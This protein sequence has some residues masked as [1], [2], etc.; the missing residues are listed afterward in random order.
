MNHGISDEDWEGYVEECS[1]PEG[2]VQIETH[3]IGCLACWEHYGQM[4]HVTNQLREA[5]AA[6]RRV[7]PLS[8]RQLHIGLQIVLARSQAQ[9]QGPGI[10]S[11]AEIQARK[12]F[13]ESLISPMCGTQTAINALHAAAV[14]SP[15]RTLNDVTFENW[16]P[17]LEQL[18][19]IAT[20]M[21]GETGA[22]L[23]RKGGS[24]SLA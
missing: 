21:C 22:D 17:F 11:P 6:L 1:S 9:K 24:I 5:T 7:L 15:A 14:S 8:D 10:L 2:V 12:N 13:L 19:S 3:L 18:T 23:I 20:V 4:K 16:D